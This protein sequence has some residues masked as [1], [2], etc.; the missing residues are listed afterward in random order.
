VRPS[1]VAVCLLALALVPTGA[2]ATEEDAKTFFAQGRRQRADGDCAGAVVAFRRALELFPQGIGALRNIAE[3]EEQLGQFA[4]ARNDWWSLRRAALQSNEPKYE[5]WD[6]DAEAGYKRLADKVA[7]ITVKLSGDELD[8]VKVTVDG[9]PLDPRLLGVELE[10]D[11][12]V[13]TIEAAYGGAAPLAEKR[14]LLAGSR[15][16]VT[17]AIPAPK[18]G[19]PA[20]TAA[21]SVA[22]TAP[23]PVPLPPADTGSGMRT[24]GFVAIGVGGL[25]LAGM[26]ASLVVRQSALSSIDATCSSHV[27]CSPS[28]QPDRDRGQTA[29]LLVNVF[30]GVAI[31]GVAAGVTLVVV[32]SRSKEP[33]KAAAGRSIT[34]GVAPVVGGI[35]GRAEVRF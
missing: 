18:P 4:S 3:C 19:A 29:S 10:R 16:V 9:K 24:A 22:P 6:K 7:R 14:S 35:G 21:P 27:G 31:A 26:I 34:I 11:L 15:E 1:S 23:P 5:G 30:G 33:A 12:G 28:L 32:G 2:G 17:L 20:P 25:G 13:H 8:R